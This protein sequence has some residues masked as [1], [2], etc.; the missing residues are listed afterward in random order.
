VAKRNLRN[1]HR[2]RLRL[3]RGRHWHWGAQSRDAPPASPAESLGI[4]TRLRNLQSWSTKN[5]VAVS[6]G[7]REAFEARL[8]QPSAPLKWNQKAKRP[9]LGSHIIIPTENAKLLFDLYRI[10]SRFSDR[11]DFEAQHCADETHELMTTY[12]G[13]MYYLD[14]SAD[15]PK[16]ERYPPVA[17][18]LRR[19]QRA[20]LADRWSAFHD[21]W[22][23]LSPHGRRLLDVA[24]RWEFRKQR[25][26]P[27][28]S[29]D[30]G[31]DAFFFDGTLLNVGRPY[32][33]P[34]LIT[35]S[36]RA[37][38]RSGNYVRLARDPVPRNILIAAMKRTIEWNSQRRRPRINE[39]DEAAAHALAS[40][41]RQATS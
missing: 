36:L 4:F 40:Y 39:Q 26:R 16:L 31:L 18:V 15:D 17:R 35:G 8:R 7:A 11:D 10:V 24:F 1:A 2:A 14:Y 21:A 20:I 30:S 37:K 25:W 12:V 38:D 19:L 5:A 9:N 13:G 28:F 34:G 32:S 41:F 23:E 29:D 3:V 27:K 6:I 33:S 22:N